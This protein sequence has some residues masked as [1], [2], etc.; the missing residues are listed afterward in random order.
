MKKQILLIILL[1]STLLSFSQEENEKNLNFFEQWEFLHSFYPHYESLEK[2]KKLTAY[3]ETRLKDFGVDYS[4]LDYSQAE[5]QHSFT[6]IIDVSIA[7]E[8]PHSLFIM[9]PLGHTRNAKKYESGIINIQTALRVIQQF[10]KEKPFLSL[11]IVFLSNEILPAKITYQGSRYFLNQLNPETSSCFFYLN[12]RSIPERVVLRTGGQGQISPFWLIDSV[13]RALSK[14]DIFFLFRGNETQF[15]RLGIDFIQSPI[16]SYLEESY[17]AIFFESISADPA[18]R[19][20]KLSGW[21]LSFP[22]ALKEFM[23]TH[24]SSYPQQSDKH[25]IFFQVRNFYFILKE[26]ELLIIILL[27]VLLFSFYFAFKRKQMR[28]RFQLF[29]SEIYNLPLLFLLFFISLFIPSLLLHFISFL[30]DFPALWQY[31][32][33]S[34]FLFKSSGVIVILVLLHLLYRYTS[35]KISAFFCRTLA[36]VLSILVFLVMSYFNI[37]YSYFALWPLICFLLITFIPFF[38]AKII[39][40]LLSFAIHIK[41]L[42]DIFTLP[43]KKALYYL[44]MD[45]FVGNIVCTF[46]LL[47]FLLMGLGLLLNPRARLPFLKRK[48]RIIFLSFFSLFL[49]PFLFLAG[50]IYLDQVFK[51]QN[52]QEIFI[53]EEISPAGNYKAQISS[54][55]PFQGIVLSK[56]GKNYQL[57]EKKRKYILTEKNGSSR[58]TMSLDSS[59]FLERVQ[60]VL[61]LEFQ[62]QVYQYTVYLQSKERMVLYDCNFPYNYD[63]R[64][65]RINLYIG[66]DPPQ[67]LDLKFITEAGRNFE[68]HCQAVFQSTELGFS[69]NE[70]YQLFEQKRIET[71]L[72]QVKHD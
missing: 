58:F 5:G 13:S 40:F 38:P 23:K 1:F 65:R 31:N 49:L 61:S 28:L 52:K 60:Y 12:L 42:V 39:F 4:I 51:E 14:E 53:L 59:T 30:R 29:M 7:G 71:K 27:L 37:S 44:I 70:K 47:P 72:L 69:G 17:P 24:Q 15:F 55:A 62:E 25:Y 22:F 68:I 16:T 66:V 9:V 33:L 6:P 10:K 3:I 48:G 34:F 50:L 64:K 20:D 26:A 57:K 19:R 2:Q 43:V 32:T 63:A 35:L 18:D 11:R 45:P 56:N 8:N 67:K 46:F 41:M 54:V 36:I 21:L